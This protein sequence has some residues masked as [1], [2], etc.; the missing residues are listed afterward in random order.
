MR[1]SLFQLSHRSSLDKL[2]FLASAADEYLPHRAAIITA[3]Q[4]TENTS[5]LDISDDP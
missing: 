2:D 5:Y 4:K 1:L 3:P